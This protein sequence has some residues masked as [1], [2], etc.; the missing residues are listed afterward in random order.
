MG[1]PT[2]PKTRSDDLHP[3]V[4]MYMCVMRALD[5]AV[6]VV[7]LD[8]IRSE[9]HQRSDRSRRRVELSDFVFFNHLPNKQLTL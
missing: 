2:L 8:G 3:G 5:A 9:L 7:F 1:S 4:S 6:P